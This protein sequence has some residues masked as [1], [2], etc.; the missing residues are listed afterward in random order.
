MS[1][2]KLIYVCGI[3]R[4]NWTALLSMQIKHYNETRRCRTK[5]DESYSIQ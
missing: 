3:Q 2:V 1:F 5:G 4:I